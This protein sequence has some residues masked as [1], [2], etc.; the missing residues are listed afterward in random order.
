MTNSTTQQAHVHSQQ[1]P[2]I[3]CHQASATS[4]HPPTQQRV[5]CGPSPANS[6]PTTL[7]LT[8]AHAPLA[9]AHRALLRGKGS[10]HTGHRPA[11]SRHIHPATFTAGA[12]RLEAAVHLA[13]VGQDVVVEGVGQVGGQVLEGTLVCQHS[14]QEEGQRKGAAEEAML[15][16]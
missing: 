7:F 1:H 16:S 13:E 5:S 3:H 15:K 9:A 11:T 10:N 12:W 4:Q 2:R 8:P 6:H 14:L